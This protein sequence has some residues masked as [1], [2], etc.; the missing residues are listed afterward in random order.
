MKE[1]LYEVNK[2]GFRIAFGNILIG[3]LKWYLDA[4]RIQI[5]YERSKSNM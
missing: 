2:Y 3:L 1:F 5:T 4:K